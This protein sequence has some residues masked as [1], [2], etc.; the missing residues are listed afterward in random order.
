MSRCHT[1]GFRSVRS[2]CHSNVTEIKAVFLNFFIYLLIILL[3]FVLAVSVVSLVSVVSVVS[4]WPFRFIVSGFSIC[5]E[6][7]LLLGTKHVLD[8]NYVIHPE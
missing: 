8:G 2:G 7:R 6:T 5:R 3:G 1:R 4:F